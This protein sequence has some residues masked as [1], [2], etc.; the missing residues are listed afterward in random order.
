M[1]FEIGF[2]AE[3]YLIWS[4]AFLAGPFLAACCPAG[5]RAPGASNGEVGAASFGELDHRCGEGGFQ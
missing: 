5:P 2:V 1:G 4:G 3:S